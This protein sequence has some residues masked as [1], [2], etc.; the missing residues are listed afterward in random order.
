M[1]EED[2][3]YV[4]LI[5]PNREVKYIFRN[6]VL[7]WFEEKVKEED[8]SVLFQVILDRDADAMETEIAGL[9]M[10]TI[11]FNDVYESFYHGFLAGIL[12]GVKGYM[13]KSDRESGHG[14]SDLFI[15]PVSRRKPAYVIEF[16]IVNRAP[17]MA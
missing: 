11:S 16:K 8:R 5:L 9:L 2:Q 10:E 17:Q 3:H 6:K 15:M 4:E 14:R 13:V 12:S 7:L 1:D